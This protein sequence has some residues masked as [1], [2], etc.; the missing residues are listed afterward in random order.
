LDDYVTFDAKGNCV[1]HGVSCLNPK[2][3]E[4]ALC[5][6][7]KLKIASEGDF[8]SDLWFFMYEF[9]RIKDLA[10]RDEPVYKLI[11]EG[12]IKGL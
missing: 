4:A 11:V 10:L 9:D 5:N 2:I 7:E 1:P 8:Y 3:C 12:K 6:Y